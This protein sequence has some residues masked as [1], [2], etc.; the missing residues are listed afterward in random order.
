LNHA[1]LG[2]HYFYDQAGQLMYQYAPGTATVTNFI[3]PG[4]KLVG[5]IDHLY[6]RMTRKNEDASPFS[7][8]LAAAPV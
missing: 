4:I 7:H 8:K 6:F 3:H 2:T 1:D 5:I